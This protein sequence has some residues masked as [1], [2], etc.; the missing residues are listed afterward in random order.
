MT[1]QTRRGEAWTGEQQK[2]NWHGSAGRNQ[3]K[4]RRNETQVNHMRGTRG[5]RGGKTWQSNRK[6]CC[7]GSSLGWQRAEAVFGHNFIHGT[8][9][10]R[11]V[12]RS[13]ALPH[14]LSHLLAVH[15]QD[16]NRWQVFPGRRRRRDSP[17]TSAAGGSVS[18]VW[19][20]HSWRWRAAPRTD[21]VPLRRSRWLWSD[22]RHTELLQE[23]THQNKLSVFVFF[24]PPHTV[25]VKV[26]DNTLWIQPVGQMM[27]SGLNNSSLYSLMA[28]H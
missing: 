25:S 5:T 21:S 26:H 1:H 28:A 12:P 16:A 6:R 2:M 23:T 24:S 20:Q 27:F 7:W 10:F 17:G 11:R 3:E 18:A 8:V 9:G 22:Q 4:G 14:L 15:R 13:S 19:W